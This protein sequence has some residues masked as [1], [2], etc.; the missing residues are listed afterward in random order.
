[1]LQHPAGFHRQLLVADARS[2]PQ[3]LRLCPAFGK[4][5]PIWFKFDIAE[6]L[7]VY[8]RIGLVCL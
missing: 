7:S 6:L 2:H 8:A 5:L 4:T 1:M 3:P